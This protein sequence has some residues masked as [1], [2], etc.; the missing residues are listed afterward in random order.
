M[1]KTNE[2]SK[3]LTPENFIYFSISHQGPTKTG[4][5][6][7]V[8]YCNADLTW[9]KHQCFIEITAKYSPGV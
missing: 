2:M 3:N 8:I 1:R 9:W 6:L 5:P 4:D 7:A